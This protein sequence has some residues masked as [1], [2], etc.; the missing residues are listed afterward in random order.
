L[1]W[2]VSLTAEEA[3]LAAQNALAECNSG[4]EDDVQC[5]YTENDYIMLVAKSTTFHASAA[6]PATAAVGILAGLAAA[7]TAEPRDPGFI[8]AHS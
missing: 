3:D 8:E 6:L 5:G 1:D 4:G 2:G 7:S